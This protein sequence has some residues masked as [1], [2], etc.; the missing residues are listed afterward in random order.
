M[1]SF[2]SDDI[3]LLGIAPV[4]AYISGYLFAAV[5]FE[6]SIRCYSSL[7]DKYGVTHIKA[8]GKRLDALQRTLSKVSFVSQLKTVIGVLIGPTA[9]VNGIFGY[10]LLS[11]FISPER[12]SIPN[13][14]I[15]LFQLILMM[16]VGDFF[17]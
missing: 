14:Y 11:T 12:R 9:I 3:F 13:F 10:F 8:D 17:L 7:Y 5:P 16:F 15:A 6:L 2:L 1:L 4:L